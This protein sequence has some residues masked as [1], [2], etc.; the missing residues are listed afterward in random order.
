MTN[1]IRRNSRELNLIE[2]REAQMLMM[3]RKN[4]EEKLE[5]ENRIVLFRK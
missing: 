1:E 3:N 5:K 4:E 2:L